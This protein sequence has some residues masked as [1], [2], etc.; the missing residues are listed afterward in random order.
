MLIVSDSN[1]IHGDYDILQSIY[2][3]IRDMISKITNTRNFIDSAIS[4]RVVSIQIRK[5]RPKVVNLFL[6]VEI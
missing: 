4:R 1:D 5:F 3:V 2:M 6:E